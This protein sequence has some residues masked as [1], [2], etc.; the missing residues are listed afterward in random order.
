MKNAASLWVKPAITLVC[1]GSLCFPYQLYAATITTSTVHNANAPDQ[2]IASAAPAKPVPATTQQLATVKVVGDWLSAA[3][4]DN[5]FNSPGA[6]DVLDHNQLERV[7]VTSTSDALNRIPG[8]FSPGPNGT[9]DDDLALNFGIRGL[10]PRLSTE[11]TVLMDG[12]PVPY[13]PYGQPQLSVAPISLGNMQAVDVIRGGG[14]VRYGPQN[15]GGIVNFVTRAI[16]KK[17]FAS[18]INYHVENSPSSSHGLKN[19]MSLL[20]GGTASN[21]FGAALLY[22]GTRGSD[23]REHSRTSHLDDTMLKLNY[24]LDKRNRFHAIAQYYDGK[25]EMPGGLTRAQYN[26]N[27]YQSKRPRDV[28]WARRTLVSGGY[29]FTGEADKFNVDYFFTKTLRS[30]FL[31]QKGFTSLSPRYYWVRGIQSQYSHEFD[32]GPVHDRFTMGYRY[33]NESN[34]EL[35][36]R[37][38][39]AAHKLPTTQSRNDRNAGGGTRAN[40]FYAD[41]E[42]DIGRW[43]ITP[44]VRFEDIHTRQTNYLSKKKF[45]GN[46][47]TTLPAL[48]VMYHVLPSWNIY[49]NTEG[50][51]SSVQYSQMPNRVAS[52]TVK[53]EKA[54]TWELGT[55]FDNGI[56]QAQL[57]TFLINF[58]D[59]YQSNQIDNTVYAQGK[60]RH[61]GVEGSIN[62]RLAALAPALRNFNVYANMAWIDAKIREAGPNKGNRVPFSSKLK[63]LVGVGYTYKGWQAN[64][65]SQFQTAQS[66]DNKNTRKE[67]ADGST[68]RIPGFA[69]WNVT[70]N[71]DFGPDTDHLKVGVGVK[72]VFNRHD[73]TRSYNDNNRGIYAGLPRTFFAQVSASL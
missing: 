34:H 19:T 37:E 47:T 21:G 24:Q 40:A 29:D 16:P 69:I 48:F 17:K 15:V 67:S 30:G 25:G 50:S 1:T 53:P 3:R 52:G 59:Q 49:A 54:R 9:G 6:R 4:A 5:V 63:G 7:G 62:Y 35:R 26:Q 72:N 32:L 36:Y 8:V 10:N 51:F 66:A 39:F 20:A 28:F 73:F 23:F 71:Y 22:S 61:H 46:Y 27:R 18:D 44:G 31:D 68:G 43:T 58:K 60:T 64:L 56:V 12:I 11:S 65:E 38:Q 33:I 2:K 41:N 14:S 70:G 55:H 42:F 13:A 57:D 45:K